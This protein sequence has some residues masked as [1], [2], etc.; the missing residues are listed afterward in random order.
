MPI[1]KRLYQTLENRDN[2]IYVEK[3]GP[4]PCNWENTWLGDGYY[5]WDSFI[6]NAHWWGNE[7]RK[8]T[9][10]YIIC[11]AICTFD[12]KKCFDLVGNT[13][14]FSMFSDAYNFLML[15]GLADNKTTV[16][17]VIEYLKNDIKVFKYK[18]IRVN[19]TLSKSEKSPYHFGMNFELGRPQYFDLRPTIQ[20][21]LFYKKSLNLRDYKIIFPAEFC[22]DYVV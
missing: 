1:T 4:F 7:V 3:K 8:F 19:G 21:C 20:I 12:D 17:R 11:T 22:S 13:E 18:A 15:A 2:P 6:E 9:N 16:K 5:F 10:G 14:H